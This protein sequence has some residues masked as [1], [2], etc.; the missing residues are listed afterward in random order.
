MGFTHT[1]RPQK[2]D[3]FGVFNINLPDN[4][5]DAN[6]H[7][8]ADGDGQWLRDAFFIPQESDKVEFVLKGDTENVSDYNGDYSLYINCQNYCGYRLYYNQGSLSLNGSSKINV[9]GETVELELTIPDENQLFEG[10]VNLPQSCSGDMII[11][12]NLFEKDTHDFVGYRH[13]IIPAGETIKNFGLG[14]LLKDGEYIVSYSVSGGDISP[15]YSNME[16]Y[17]TENGV[18]EYIDDAKIYVV[19]NNT[20]IIDLKFEPLV[21]S[22]RIE[23]TLTNAY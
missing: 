13:F 1:G 19:D 22:S 16:L 18:S 11:D 8:Y 2:H 6:L 14:Y 23:G 7:I 15:Y 10:T 12:V 5:D 21:C 3:I 4:I 9:N 17:V 20:K